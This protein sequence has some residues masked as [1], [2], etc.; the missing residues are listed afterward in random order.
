MRFPGGG[1]LREQRGTHGTRQ[2]VRGGRLGRKPA[3]S[4]GEA[5]AA[6]RASAASSGRASPVGTAPP[7]AS[8][9][10]GRRSG[11]GRR[12]FCGERRR[13]RQAQRHGVRQQARRLSARSHIRG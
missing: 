8:E 9:P 10:R 3:G 11:G 1:F 5:A 13:G 6:D 12:D 7:R 2:P 4:V